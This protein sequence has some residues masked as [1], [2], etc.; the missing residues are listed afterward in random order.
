[1]KHD[2]DRKGYA[3]FARMLL[4]AGGL[5]LLVACADNGGDNPPPVTA[6]SLPV[7]LNEVMVALINH[8]AD[9]IWAAMWNNPQTDREWRELER[10]AYQVEIGGA[11]LK[12]PGTGPLDAAWTA[13]PRWQQ[14]ADQLQADG[15]RAVSAVR[16][17]NFDLMQRAGDQLVETCEA[18]HREFKPDLPTMDMFGELPLLPPVSL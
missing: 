9:P 13:S 16:S 4:A 3:G 8:S 15:V 14:L 12:L 2:S 17:R 10:L 1:M 7:S 6:A 11:L 18:C 5:S